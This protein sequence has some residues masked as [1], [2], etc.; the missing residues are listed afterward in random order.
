MLAHVRA[1]L[2]RENIVNAM[3]QEN[4]RKADWKGRGCGEAQPPRLARAER[5]GILPTPSDGNTLRLVL[6]TRPRSVAH[7]MLRQKWLFFGVGISGEF[8]QILLGSHL[9]ACL[10]MWADI[11]SASS[12]AIPP[13]ETR[14]EDAPSTG[15]VEACPRLSDASSDGLNQS[16]R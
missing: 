7:F 2:E 14:G 3:R 15:R 4:A 8:R 1:S 11:L 9:R 10:K 16:D 6:W 13:P 12:S 5:F